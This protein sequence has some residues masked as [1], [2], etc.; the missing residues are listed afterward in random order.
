MP[1]GRR[2]PFRSVVILAAVLLLAMRRG[3]S[4]PS[5]PFVD[6]LPLT[7]YD[8]N[9]AS[10]T[11]ASCTTPVPMTSG[12][13]VP[14]STAAI[15]P[16]MQS[17]TVT[18]VTDTSYN[19]A[20]FV[21]FQDAACTQYDVTVSPV[22]GPLGQPRCASMV[23]PGS[24]Y[25][26]YFALECDVTSQNAFIHFPCNV[27]CSNCTAG[28]NVSTTTVSPV[29]FLHRFDVCSQGFSGPNVGVL[30]RGVAACAAARL[31]TWATSSN[32]SGVPTVDRYVSQDVCSLHG[33]I[34]C[35]VQPPPPPAYTSN[36]TVLHSQC[37]DS[38]CSGTCTYSTVPN[39]QCTAQIGGFGPPGA[40]VFA[41][42]TCLTQAA[43]CANLVMFNGPG[44]NAT[45]WSRSFWPVCNKC[46]AEPRFGPP[47][48]N[49]STMY[50]E[51]LCTPSTGL[52]T[53]RVNCSDSAC[54]QCTT[55]LNRPLYQCQVD[56]QP[57]G[58][59]RGPSNNSVV[60]WG[61]APCEAVERD[62]YF[63]RPSPTAP[64][65]TA[66]TACNGQPTASFFNAADQCNGDESDSCGNFHKQSVTLAVC[67]NPSPNPLPLQSTEFSSGLCQPGWF[68]LGESNTTESRVVTCS[69]T[70]A[71]CVDLGI[72]T[73][74]GG[75]NATCGDFNGEYR[76][77][78]NQCIFNPNLGGYAYARC[79][80]LNQI[81]SIDTGCAASCIGPCAYPGNTTI[82]AESCGVMNTLVNATAVVYKFSEC[83]FATVSRWFNSNNCS[84]PPTETIAVQ[85]QYCSGSVNDKFISYSC[86]NLPGFNGSVTK[87]K[88]ALTQVLHSQCPDIFCGTSGGPCR[89]FL[90]DSGVCVPFARNHHKSIRT[91]CTGGGMCANFVYFNSATC[92]WSNSTASFS[93]IC[94]SCVLY[95]GKH[96]RVRCFTFNQTAV[97]DAECDP[98]CRQ[99]NQTSA[100]VRPP[101]ACVP[102]G[103]APNTWVANTGFT[104][105]DGVLVERFSN[106]ACDA[107]G[108]VYSAIVADGECENGGNSFRCGYYA[109]SQ[110]TEANFTVRGCDSANMVTS[111]VTT[112]FCQ[113]VNQTLTGSSDAKSYAVACLAGTRHCYRGYYYF[114]PTC[115]QTGGNFAGT[116]GSCNKRYN[117]GTYFRVV[118]HLKSQSITL[119]D[120]CDASCKN[121]GSIDTNVR[122]MLQCT[123]G[124]SGDNTTVRFWA[125]YE[126]DGV[127][128]LTWHHSKSCQG[129]PTSAFEVA[130]DE[131]TSNDL[132]YTSIHCN[133]EANLTVS[134]PVTLN[135]TVI[136]QCSDT[137]CSQNCQ[138]KLVNSG[139]CTLN[140]VA[141][142]LSSL[143]RCVPPGTG[144]VSTMCAQVSFFPQSSNCTGVSQLVTQACNSC[145]QYNDGTYQMMLC[146]S[147]SDQYSIVMGCSANCATCPSTPGSVV[148]RRFLTCEVGAMNSGTS[149]QSAGLS[150]CLTVSVQ[151]FLGSS[152]DPSQQLFNFTTAANGLCG[153]KT[154]YICGEDLQQP[155]PNPENP[156]PVITN[157][158]CGCNG[159]GTN[160]PTSTYSSGSCQ[161][162]TASGTAQGQS[163][164]WL[165]GHKYASASTTCAPTSALAYSQCAMMV[166]FSDSGCT[167]YSRF[168]S[169]VC[170][171]CN[172][173]GGGYSLVTC[174]PN[175]TQVANF[176]SCS[177][178][179]CKNCQAPL[180]QNNPAAGNNPVFIDVCTNITG[181][182]GGYTRL[183]GFVPC[184][185]IAVQAWFTNTQCQGAPSE[186]Y[187]MGQSV[188]S[189]HMRLSCSNNIAANY[190]PQSISSATNVLKSH[191]D[192]GACSG[193]CT[194][195]TVSNG[196]CV[197]DTVN[198]FAMQTTCLSQPQMCSQI[199]IFTGAGCLPSQFQFVYSPACGSC[200]NFGDPSL[201]WT[202]ITCDLT[203]GTVTYNAGCNSVCGGCTKLAASTRPLNTCV[204]GFGDDNTSAINMGLSPC[205]VAVQNIWSLNSNTLTG[206]A[207]CPV[208]GANQAPL[209]TG[210]ATIVGSFT[211]A[212]G[213]CND[214]D[215]MSCGN[216]NIFSVTQTKCPRCALTGGGVTNSTR[217]GRPDIWCDIAPDLT[218]FPAGTCQPL[219]GNGTNLSY[220]VGCSAQSDLNPSRCATVVAYRDAQCT[221]FSNFF[222]AVCGQC[223]QD[224][225]GN[226]GYW[227]N[228]CNPTT[229]GVSFYSNCSAGCNLA[230]CS[231]GTA[232]T[233][234]G[235]LYPYQGCTPFL[236]PNAPGGATI[237]IYLK[238]EGVSTCDVA[239]LTLF[240]DTNCMKP[241]NTVTVP[242]QLCD[243]HGVTF[244]CGNAPGF[245]NSKS[246]RLSN[247]VLQNRCEN[248]FCSQ[249]CKQHVYEADLCVPRVARANRQSEGNS[250]RY[251]C[252]RSRYCTKF[253]YFNTSSCLGRPL[254]VQ[255]YTCGQ[256][257]MFPA[258][259]FNGNASYMLTTCD[260]LTGD[261]TFKAGCDKDCKV[262][263]NASDAA[264]PLDTCSATHM[265]N[266]FSVTAGVFYCDVVE[267]RDYSSTDCESGTLFEKFYL[268][269]GDCNFGDSYFC[270]MPSFNVPTTAYGDSNVTETQCWCD[271][272]TS[273]TTCGERM[274]KSNTCQTY[275]PTAPSY[276]A[277]YSYSVTCQSKV[278]M[279]ISLIY[280]NGTVDPN[281]TQ[282]PISIFS[283]VCGSCYKNQL[284]NVTGY[285][286]IMCGTSEVS[287]VT[288]FEGCDPTCTVCVGQSRAFNL[289][290]CTVSLQTNL[291]VQVM[292]IAPC[293]TVSKLYYSNTVCKGVPDYAITEGQN[294]CDGV[295]RYTCS[296]QPSLLPALPSSNVTIVQCAND[297]CG[298]QCNTSTLPAQ[299][300][301]P[302]SSGSPMSE[303]YICPSQLTAAMSAQ[304]CMIGAI[305][306]DT[307]CATFERIFTVAC[308]SCFHSLANDGT[309]NQLRCSATTGSQ[310]ATLL[311]G[312][313][314][315]CL[316][317]TGAALTRPYNTCEQTLNAANQSSTGKT[318]VNRGLV[319]C[320]TVTR[321]TYANV[322]CSGNYSTMVSFAAGACE[323]N[324]QF[325][326]GFGS[327]AASTTTTAP[328]NGST[329]TTT[330]TT[331][332]PVTADTQ[333]TVVYAAT[334]NYT[335]TLLVNGL[336]TV[337]RSSTASASVVNASVSVDQLTLD[338]TGTTV[339]FHFT[340]PNAAA[341]AVALAASISSNP[342]GTA[343]MLQASTVAVG[344]NAGPA[345]AS[346]MRM[347]GIIV[348]AVVGALVLIGIIAVVAT[349]GG[350]RADSTSRQRRVGEAKRDD[351]EQPLHTVQEQ[352]LYE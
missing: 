218:T 55:V 66:A 260:P 127:S 309:F 277:N 331:A 151:Q 16:A 22:C 137:E 26:Q 222:K 167:N 144:G 23:R 45:N 281:C 136:V 341:F 249:D 60:N 58:R 138:S 191:C 148:T 270:G 184:A 9:C 106:A 120:N 142:S 197:V 280:F 88:G 180:T 325:F 121:C 282:P 61:V 158:Y 149:V 113:S 102:V 247:Q 261:A 134:N 328:S 126:C 96:L 109:S 321:L 33:I 231:S 164:A 183:S 5:P 175:T 42:S 314:S 32:C 34:D 57:F 41:K 83:A 119:L 248:N 323:G 173:V 269:A 107:S 300:C 93:V 147:G 286:K 21:V 195:E 287:T 153:S 163:T 276:L 29:V 219:I 295:D 284:P 329:T 207:A 342:T 206:T 308:G 262:C 305:F 43:M 72:F 141:G 230:T 25:T 214:R 36:Q 293:S 150:P 245:N 194:Y 178:D 232:T 74:A 89:E 346:H 85:Q 159:D 236:T 339:V 75:P 145:M 352:S 7:Y 211:V 3:T 111:L 301:L 324:A 87:P 193:E 313:N 117:T 268:S 336:V 44:C 62:I 338:T 18:C 202:Q 271:P 264:R 320:T 238:N 186:T 279:C 229:L 255:T 64:T 27:D 82:A 275:G 99:C 2:A 242:Q 209:T 223:Q 125:V 56:Y 40:A 210:A 123:P 182:L 312:C 165:T 350:R 322:N 243:S 53:L 77:V 226:M 185:P 49:R 348:G 326:C 8:C 71:T 10:G 224:R 292:A 311:T 307:Q 349:R 92:A 168:M 156:L 177:D 6:A 31:Q 73:Y 129:G 104:N 205:Y 14:Q 181:I 4:S 327:N 241:L 161:S 304:T 335:R 69:S 146:N 213:A 204:P 157:F 152:C 188:C 351:L 51:I 199:A 39:G 76:F 30:N 330:T 221:Q 285:T 344:G 315:G 251:R 80:T 1:S 217:A 114:G 294:N 274:F 13:C 196:Q 86:G 98:G 278:E 50:M 105:C 234:S 216:F 65:P 116:C 203:T 253:I 198:Q 296:E 84:G 166:I 154:R 283:G 95:Q 332:A 240:N 267:V 101:A 70:T 190:P 131:C 215:T 160:C 140:D 244:S 302:R 225:F 47:G 155:L 291:R 265:A 162:S 37:A 135:T 252:E 54:Q 20:T 310:G 272:V 237:T 343:A 297:R 303:Q 128:L 254:G 201:G 35:A 298:G 187:Y 259:Q 68:V 233:S 94:N 28:G 200:V 337:L 133:N 239:Q 176:V 67:Q 78:C 316:A 212:Q 59:R 100:S 19:C 250:S 11:N 192:H 132:G 52:V 318:I 299:A 91:T 319:P 273:P 115:A 347:I 112:S 170:G 340:G 17:S 257:T 263:S 289:A 235:Q 15:L 228:V 97:L 266:I 189:N 139:Q 288:A 333:F 306:S 172:F 334:T 103:V 345:P 290:A 90:H 220:M 124:L 48:E 118:C 256:C 179:Q 143:V 258:G 317:C 38:G 174:S 46:I 227:I 108:I 169:L 208:N 12:Q 130:Q 171:S 81:M 79:D 63:T 122:P 110:S 246:A 24:T